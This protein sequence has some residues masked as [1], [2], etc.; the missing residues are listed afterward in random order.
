MSSK[1]TVTQGQRFKSAVWALAN[2]NWFSAWI[3]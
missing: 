2:P 1:A 3:K